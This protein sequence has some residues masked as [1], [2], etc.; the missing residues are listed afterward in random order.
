MN[1]ESKNPV[2]KTLKKGRGLPGQIQVT[3]ETAGTR[4]SI[5]RVCFKIVS[6][7]SKGC[8]DDH[9]HDDDDDDDNAQ[10][11]LYVCLCTLYLFGLN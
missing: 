1:C 7:L 9:D 4:P 6:R 11:V 5:A 10:Y 2:K 3:Y 8:D